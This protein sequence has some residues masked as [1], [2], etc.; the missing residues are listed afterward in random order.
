MSS[1]TDDKFVVIAGS[2]GTNGAGTGVLIGF[3]FDKRFKQEFTPPISF[4]MINKMIRLKD[5]NT[6]VACTSSNI[7]IF[8]LKFDISM[9]NFKLILNIPLVKAFDVPSSKH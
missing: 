8:D 4:G 5:K 7:V 9:E 2:S 1:S 6:F 3:T